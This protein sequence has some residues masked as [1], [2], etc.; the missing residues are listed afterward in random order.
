[1]GVLEREQKYFATVVE[2]MRLTGVPKH[3]Y[4]HYPWEARIVVKNILAYAEQTGDPLKIFTSDFYEF[5]DDEIHHKLAELA[6][7]GHHIQIILAARPED[8]DLAKWRPISEN[9]NV[10]ITFMPE[11]DATLNHVWLAGTSFRYE[12]PHKNYNYEISDTYPEFPA[13]F[14]F[15]NDKDVKKAEEAWDKILNTCEHKP[16]FHSN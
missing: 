3:F 12:R 15:K 13:R 1:M 5:Y 6:R 10:N 14:A 11:Y 9:E 4:N 8:S 7:K 2:T 16:L